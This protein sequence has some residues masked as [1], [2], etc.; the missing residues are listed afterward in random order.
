VQ[1]GAA[2]RG[3]HARGMRRLYAR[4]LPLL[5]AGTFRLVPLSRGS[6]TAS[7]NAPPSPCVSLNTPKRVVMAAEVRE[8]RRGARCR[9]RCG[10][11]CQRPL[12]SKL[13]FYNEYIRGLARPLRAA[14]KV[15][16]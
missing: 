12:C 5:L 9:V 6:D 13:V 10:G 14:T 4:T 8:Q 11:P 7:T 3:P 1:A 15:A 16:A 2:C